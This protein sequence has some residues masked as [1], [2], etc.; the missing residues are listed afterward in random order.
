VI[1]RGGDLTVETGAAIVFQDNGS[2]PNLA[3]AGIAGSL[4]IWEV[5]YGD[6]DLHTGRPRVV[7]GPIFAKLTAAYNAGPPQ[8]LVFEMPAAQT[9]KMNVGTGTYAW[10]IGLTWPDGNYRERA[11]GFVNVGHA[12]TPAHR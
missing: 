11:G 7:D 6:I 3:T 12:R 2:W 9:L 4:V 1:N 8:Q 10:S 5:T